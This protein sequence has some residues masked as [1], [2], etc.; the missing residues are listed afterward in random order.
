MRRLH[1]ATVACLAGCSATV[2]SPRLDT[3]GD[4]VSPFDRETQEMADPAVDPCDDFY[5]HACGGWISGAQIEPS[6]EIAERATD[7]VRER[8]NRVLRDLLE[9]SAPAGREVG[10]L[11]LF[12]ASCMAEGSEADRAGE[13]ALGRRLAR[14]DAIRSSRDVQAVLRELQ[15]EGMQAF[16]AYSGQPDRADPTRHRGQ[17]DQ[18]VL[19]LR[20]GELRDPSPEGEKRRA[21]YAAHLARMFALAGL[22]QARAG[23]D[24]AQVL[25]LEVALARVSLS[26]A[27]SWDPA[28]TEHPMSIDELSALAPRVD[29]PP[30][31][32]MVGH[33]TDRALN[34]AAPDYLRT[35]DRL[36]A[37]RP[38]D[39]LAAFLR[40]RLLHAL[41]PALPSRLAEEHQRFSRRGVAPASRRDVCRLATVRAMGVELSRQFSRR[42]ISPEARSRAEAVTRAVRDVI[43]DSIA[44]Q[45]WLSPAAR[46]ATEEKLRM[47]SLK[48]GYPSGWPAAGS[49]PLR[50]GEHLEN[51]IAAAAFE[52]RRAWQRAGAERRRTSW[53]MTVYPNDAPGMAAARL[54]FANGFPDAFTNS[55]ILNAAVLQPPR[56]DPGAP[57]EV[58]YATLG[59]L[60]AHELIHVVE[61]H[62]FDGSGALRERWAATDIAAHDLRRTCAVEQANELIGPDGARLDGER[63]SGENV[64]DLS[65]LAHAYEAMKREIPLAR[66]GGAHGSATARRFF[67]A[68]AQ[69]WC[70]VMRPASE[71]ER[72]SSDPHAPPHFRVNWPL[73]NMPEFSAAF[74][75]S[76]DARMSRSRRCA[77]W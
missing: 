29:W 37:G 45:G 53:E 31:L 16:L 42:A 9:S 19:G 32:S 28:L 15:G 35:L 21:D 12:F 27:E 56:F 43:A 55:I 17:I 75:C 48:V 77:V 67:Y 71:R 26:F 72:F 13:R 44:G 65:G 60:V 40:W 20:P 33:P 70:A 23:R 63:T 34:V 49:F 10:R 46:A 30:F 73:S 76:P 8:T 62:M 38:P 74:S 7:L 3:R 14:I 5:R 39:A 69:R 2:D 50:A 64:A 58:Q 6:K 18:G 24:A 57:P 51:T 68:Y 66:R 61:A 1:L 54:T 22:D 47:T 59:V 4:K 36:L 11:R 41:G 25:E 52:Q